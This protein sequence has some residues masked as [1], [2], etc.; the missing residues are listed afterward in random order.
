MKDIPLLWGCRNTRL[1]IRCLRGVDCQPGDCRCIFYLPPGVTVGMCPNVLQT[2][3]D[4]KVPFAK[5]S[6]Y[7]ELPRTSRTRF[8]VLPQKVHEILV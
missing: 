4:E 3:L 7:I 8:K 5:H 6:G 1:G 2:S